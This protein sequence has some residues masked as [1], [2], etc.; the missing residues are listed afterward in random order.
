MD[1]ARLKH[2]HQKLHKNGHRIREPQPRYTQGTGCSAQCHI[3]LDGIKEKFLQNTLLLQMLKATK[4]KLLVEANMDKQLG[5]GIHV[6]NQN[7]LKQDLWSGHGWMSKM[8]E[9]IRELNP[10]SMNLPLY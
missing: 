7:A 3:C 5:T 1:V 10:P 2:A 4:P 8:L 9:E 6:R